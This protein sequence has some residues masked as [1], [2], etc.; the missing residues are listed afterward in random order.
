MRFTVDDADL[1]W[2]RDVPHVATVSVER[3]RWEVRGDG[4]VLAHVAASLVAHG[5][6]PVD[7]RQERATLED[8]FLA[9]THP[10]ERSA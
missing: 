1:S 3:G 9:L 4:P 5:H 7:L 6:E 2:L 10:A 8:V